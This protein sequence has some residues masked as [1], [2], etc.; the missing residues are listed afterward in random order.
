MPEAVVD[1]A[2]ALSCD[3]D[4]EAFRHGGVHG[5]FLGDYFD[6]CD[7]A[8]SYVNSKE[9]PVTIRPWGVNVNSYV[10]L[11]VFLAFAKALGWKMPDEFKPISMMAPSAVE[12]P[13]VA[14]PTQSGRVEVGVMVSLPHTTK[15]L[16]AVFRVMR[17]HW[18][19]FAT[20]GAPKQESVGAAID[21]AMGWSPLANGSPSRS[22]QAL[23]A[24]IRRDDV[25][26]SDKRSRRR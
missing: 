5:D 8:R 14:L 26:G 13:P 6:R 19:D 24:A 20:A 16:E 21:T 12:A 25:A 4:P 3:I 17:E 11:S 9:L 18:R 22:A 23:A 15:T 2:V 10:R 7:V 1:D